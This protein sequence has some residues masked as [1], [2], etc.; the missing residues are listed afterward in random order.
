M[1]V[2]A[3]HVRVESK[4]LPESIQVR[5]LRGRE[6]ISQ[7]YEFEVEVL[8]DD[9]SGIDEAALLDEGIQIHFDTDPD[10][11]SS[12]ARTIHG[13]V[14]EVHDLGV[15]EARQ[16]VYRIY[17]APRMWRLTLATTLD[18]FL[19]ANVPDIVKARLGRHQLSPAEEGEDKTA[20][21]DPPDLEFRLA[22]TYEAR[23]FVVQYK[24]SDLDFVQRLCEHLGIFYFFE[25]RPDRDLLVFGDDNQAFGRVDPDDAPLPW[26]PRGE[27]AGVFDLGSRARPIPHR[28][29]T[30]DY[31]YRTPLLDMLG[32][33]ELTAPG[34]GHDQI[35]YGTHFKTP[36]E[37]KFFAE[38]RAQEARAQRKIYEGK[39]TDPRLRAGARFRL[40]GHPRGD[41]D[42]L[43]TEVLH[44][45][46]QVAF[47]GEGTNRYECTF[48]AIEA[49]LAFRPPRVTKVPR[50]H[51]VLTGKVV[52]DGDYADVDDQ[53][54]YRVRFL[55]DTADRGEEQASRPIRMMQPHSGPGYGMHFPMRGGVEVALSFVDGDPDRPIIAGTVPNPS[56]AS[57]VTDD[58][59]RR[60]V[61]RTGRGNEINIDDDESSPRIKM[62]TPR[63]NSYL[64]LGAPN[65]AEDGVMLSTAGSAST[66][67]TLG[68]GMVGSIG[69]AVSLIQDLRSSGDIITLAEKPG[70]IEKML[71]VGALVDVVAELGTAGVEIARTTLSATADTTAKQAEAEG[72]NVSSANDRQS[73]Q[74]VKQAEAL[75]ALGDPP[76][77]SDTSAKAVAQRNLAAKYAAYAAVTARLPNERKAATDARGRVEELERRRDIGGETGLDAQLVTARALRDAAEKTVLLSTEEIDGDTVAPTASRW[78]EITPAEQA[79][80]LSP[81]K[82]TE[83]MEAADA[84]AALSTDAEKAQIN[85]LKLA[86][87]DEESARDAVV[88][89]EASKELKQRTAEDAS[90]VASKSPAARALEATTIALNGLRV[91]VTLYSAIL[92]GI[93]LYQK[94]K[95]AATNE[96][97]WQQLCAD[98]LAMGLRA[99]PGLGPLGNEKVFQDEASAMHLVGSEDSMGVYGLDRLFMW[100][101]SINLHGSEQIVIACGKDNTAITA[102][103]TTKAAKAAKAATAPPLPQP[104]PIPPKLPKIKAPRAGVLQ[105]TGAIVLSEQKAE[106]RAPTMYMT[107][108]KLD[109]RTCAAF[110]PPAEPP[111]KQTFVMDSAAAEIALSAIGSP[112]AKATFTLTGDAAP[113]VVLATEKGTKKATFTTTE[114][115]FTLETSDGFSLATTKKA[116]DIELDAMGHASILVSGGSRVMLKTDGGAEVT[117]GKKEIHVKVGSSEITLGPSGVKLKGTK[118]EVDGMFSVNGKSLAEI[119]GGQVKIG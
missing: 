57:P 44:D 25:E 36:D 59:K 2:T 75:R 32:E 99:S 110:V 91:G 81:D 52:A 3:R 4:A 93:N 50:I 9:M 94:T 29:V 77:E 54:R 55:F 64:Q 103:E 10:D 71:A 21:G 85:K 22:R 1:P 56:T 14:R 6:R 43:V 116:A 8:T 7:P 100:S 80:A 16:L 45:A 28:F 40:E 87:T 27:K 68:V 53:G 111:K 39:S 23:E 119:T 51:G 11:P 31:N 19:D 118:V 113:K 67:G 82:Q 26:V 72:K 46:E 105:W 84:L 61:I 30:R 69:T 62:S 96:V 73:L 42:L 76:P 70:L 66:I 104:P 13:M 107:G 101:K 97:A 15:T 98:I 89:A 35:E 90:F 20:Q 37:A 95:Q 17:V 114:G 12:V 79:A 106:V 78:S 65:G 33:T 102:S 88:S 63:L 112:T 109:I 18:I 34:P 115:K 5:T 83:L 47:D 24:E 86:V 117:L 108:D 48:H 74:Q 60:N 58:N 41:L 49:Q 38:I 92:G